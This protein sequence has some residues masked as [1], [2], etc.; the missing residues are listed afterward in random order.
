MSRREGGMELSP[1]LL[2]HG[3]QT[4]SEDFLEETSIQV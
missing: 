3:G 1:Q 4:A 2:W